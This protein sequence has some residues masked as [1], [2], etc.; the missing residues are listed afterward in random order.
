ME[1]SCAYKIITNI[2]VVFVE[3]Q[4]KSDNEFHNIYSK[5][6]S[7]AEKCGKT[8]LTKPHTVG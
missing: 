8:A 6:K 4:N 2:P 3:I 5:A 1:I 7:M